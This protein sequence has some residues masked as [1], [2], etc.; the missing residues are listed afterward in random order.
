MGETCDADIN[1][2]LIIKI[3]FLDNDS[4]VVACEE[5][6]VYL[7]HFWG[8]HERDVVGWII[9]TANNKRIEDI[10]F[11]ADEGGKIDGLANGERSSASAIISADN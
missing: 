3:K 4:L 9:S 7:S 11:V 5:L 1:N 2:I 10:E 8:D 6:I